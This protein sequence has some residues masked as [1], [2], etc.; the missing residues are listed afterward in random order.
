LVF[1]INTLDRKRKNGRIS[2][3]EQ[4]LGW[5]S[6]TIKIKS[7]K[8]SGIDRILWGRKTHLLSLGTLS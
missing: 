6:N 8:Y 2:C 3:R 7:S 5:D 1:E 4:H